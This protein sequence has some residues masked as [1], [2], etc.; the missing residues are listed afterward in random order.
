MDSEK[1]QQSSCVS[2]QVIKPQHCHFLVLI[3]LVS[4]TLL[5]RVCK[6]GGGGPINI[7]IQDR[8]IP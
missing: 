8:S 7:R 1:T 5:C 4:R 3:I 6:I 2:I